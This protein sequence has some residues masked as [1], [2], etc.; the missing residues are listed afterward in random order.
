MNILVSLLLVGHL[1]NLDNVV[2]EAIPCSYPT[3]QVQCVIH[4]KC[5]LRTVKRLRRSCPFN[6]DYRILELIVKEIT[7]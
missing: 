7:L 2:K 4:S 1:N 5:P 6:K 3:E